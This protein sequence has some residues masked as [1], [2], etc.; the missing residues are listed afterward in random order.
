VA[1]AAGGQTLVVEIAP[2]DGKGAALTGKF[3]LP[4]E[5]KAVRAAVTPCMAAKEKGRD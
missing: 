3:V 1:D 2:A 4:H 5:A